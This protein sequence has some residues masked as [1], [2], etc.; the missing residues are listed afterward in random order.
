MMRSSP[1]FTFS[2]RRLLI[3]LS[4]IG[5][6]PLAILGLWSL[7]MADQYQQ[8]EQE[9][10]MLDQARALSSAVDAELDG[11]IA[12]LASMARTPAMDAGEL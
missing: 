11:S 2:L 6:L 1:G 5:L 9:R 7:H 4:A 10:A 3:L 12:T 8:R